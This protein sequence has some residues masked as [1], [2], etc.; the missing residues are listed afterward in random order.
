MTPEEIIFSSATIYFPFFI[1]SYMVLGGGIKYIDDAFDEKT[2]SKMKAILLAPVVAIFWVFLMYLS[3]ASATILGAIFL[4]V[5]FRNKVDNI[6]FHVGAIAIFCG[7]AAL[8]LFKI[9]HFDWGP[10]VFLTI[11]GVLDEVGNDYVDAH[12]HINKWIYLF[13][14]YRFVMKVAVLLLVAWGIYGFEYF[15]AFIGFD[16]AYATIGAYSAK[17]K[18]HHKYSLNNFHL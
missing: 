16:L 13:F 15:L 4:A 3:P 18:K 14:E 1:A 8:Y 17:L 5:L 12:P 2:Y 6:G 10:L 11:A 9:I 7:L